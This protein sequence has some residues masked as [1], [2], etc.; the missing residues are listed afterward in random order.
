MLIGATLPDQNDNFGPN[1]NLQ[2]GG[3]AGGIAEREA[4]KKKFA[5]GALGS[6]ISIV[7][8]LKGENGLNELEHYIDKAFFQIVIQ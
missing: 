6:L 7:D 1:P 4:P 3:G 8:M 2:P 5:D